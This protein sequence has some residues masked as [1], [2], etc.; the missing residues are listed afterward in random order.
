LIAKLLNWQFGQYSS[1][2]VNQLLLFI[3]V[4]LESIMIHNKTLNEGFL[5]TNT[6]TAV[7]HAGDEDA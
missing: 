3:I 4:P 6:L 2:R 5:V 7:Q 1:T